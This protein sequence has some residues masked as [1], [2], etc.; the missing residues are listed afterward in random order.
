MRRSWLI[1][2]VAAGLVAGCDDQTDLTAP[3]APRGVYSVTGDS[4]V[5]LHWLA[6]TETDVAVYRVYES[7]CSHGGGCPY[8]RVGTTGGTSFEVGGLTDGVTRYFA[9]SAVDRNGNE[10]AL[11]YDD[12]FDTPRPAGT[13]LSLTN[14]ETNSALAGYDFSAY[15]VRGA[16][17]NATDIYYDNTG[18][19]A[20]MVCPFV[21]TDIQDAGYATTLDAVDVAPVAGWSPTGTV[22]LIDGHCYVVLTGDDHYAKFRVTSVTTGQVVIDWA[23]QT[24]LANPELRLRRPV[25][26]GARVRRS[27]VVASR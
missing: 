27:P 20:S 18:G 19:V 5:T 22:E 7:P 15:T 13:G 25:E 1:L 11:S 21:D 2:L 3:A 8:T 10:S 23:Y 14:S 26:E 16:G 6:N 24:D 4:K 9:V 17:D 12:V